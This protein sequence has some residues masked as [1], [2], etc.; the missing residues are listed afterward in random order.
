MNRGTNG[1]SPGFQ[2]GDSGF[3]TRPVYHL[4]TTEILRYV[5]SELFSLFTQ[6]G[7]PVLSRVATC[8]SRGSEAGVA[9]GGISGKVFFGCNSGGW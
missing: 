5:S 3:D 7:F 4:L 9:A 6:A 1:E 8:H 2:P